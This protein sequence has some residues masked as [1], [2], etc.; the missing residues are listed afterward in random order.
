MKTELIAFALQSPLP[1]MGGWG[2]G[3]VAIPEG[4]PCFGMEYDSIDVSVHCGLTFSGK[5]KLKGQPEETKGM[6]VVGFDT[7]HA[8]DSMEA[9]PDKESVMNEANDLKEQLI[10]Y[11][12]KGETT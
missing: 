9:W 5:D 2:N 4:H 12:P 8:G 11:Q 10:N 3:Y 7:L 1:G 6:W